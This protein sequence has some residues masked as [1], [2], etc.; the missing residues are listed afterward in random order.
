[1]RYLILSLGLLLSSFLT[2]A[3]LPFEF[4]VPAHMR[5]TPLEIQA[6]KRWCTDAGLA[7]SYCKNIPVIIYRDPLE[8]GPDGKTWQ[9]LGLEVTGCTTIINT[10]SYLYGCMAGMLKDGRV[11]MISTPPD[12]VEDLNAIYGA[13]LPGCYHTLYRAILLAGHEI[14]HKDIANHSQA[15]YNL[16]ASRWNAFLAAHASWL[17]SVADFY[18][19]EYYD[20]FAPESE[21]QQLQDE[22][23]LCFVGKMAE[24]YKAAEVQLLKISPDVWVATE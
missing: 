18:W 9:D 21:R 16:E 15:F 13:G 12:V 24:A 7:L 10:W 4:V 22:V 6:G 23:P 14:T 17:Y 11:Y 2:A 20:L 19:L 8:R 5:P 1:M 3:E